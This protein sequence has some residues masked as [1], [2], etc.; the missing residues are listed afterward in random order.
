MVRATTM[1]CRKAGCRSGATAKGDAF[2]AG[3]VAMC[4]SMRRASLVAG[5]PPTAFARTDSRDRLPFF[6]N[7]NSSATEIRVT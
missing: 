7:I 6:R 3:S 1:P 5:P 2:G 4:R